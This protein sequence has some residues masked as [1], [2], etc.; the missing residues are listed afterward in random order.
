MKILHAMA[1]SSVGGA[2]TFFLDAIKALHET[3]HQQRVITRFNNHYRVEEIQ[4]RDIPLKKAP[5]NRHWRFP[6]NRVFQSAI[7]DFKP[8]IVHYYMGR[9]GT[10][11]VKGDHVNLGW[12]G[13]YYKPSRFKNCT[14]HAAVTQDIADHIIKQG[15][16]ANNVFVLHIYA[17]FPEGQAIDRAEFDTPDDAPLLLSL[18]RLH[19]KKGIDVLL[20]A[21]AQVPDAYLWIAGSGPL[22]DA[23]KVQMKRLQLEN[24]I[25]F[26]GWRND[27]ADLLATS[28]ICMF[29]SR[30]EPFGAVTI[31]AWGT[32]TPLIA[33]KA[34]GPSAY[35]CHE[36][37][38]L[39][40][41]IDDVDGLA[42]AINHMIR[43]TDLQKH[44]VKNGFDTY[45]KDFTREAYK[46]NATA[47]YE[48]LLSRRA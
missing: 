32:K 34:A 30:Y 38:G 14:Y 3:E 15:V 48:E 1:G 9:A 8:N 37:N 20:E 28:D 7:Q 18:S 31:E 21:M 19:E 6:T 26:L 43:D 39:L 41:E 33:C 24:R 13:G 11:S 36:E 35:V 27:R 47:L 10:F 45:Q 2:E 42:Q 23:L 25:R 17:E 46:K 12:Y 16:P 4:K 29:P 5:F 40:V 44:V 22:E